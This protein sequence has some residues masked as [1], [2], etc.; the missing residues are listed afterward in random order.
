MLPLLQAMPVWMAKIVVLRM[1]VLIGWQA[2]RQ[3][4]WPIESQLPC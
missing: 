4:Q 1:Q 3:A 2:V